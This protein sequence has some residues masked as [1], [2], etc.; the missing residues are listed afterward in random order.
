[1]PKP[2]RLSGLCLQVVESSHFI[3][4]KTADF[5]GL[6]F[7][8]RTDGDS[9]AALARSASATTPYNCS[10][11]PK[12]R[13]G[14]SP[15]GTGGSEQILRSGLLPPQLARSGHASNPAVQCLPGLRRACPYWTR[16]NH[17]PGECRPGSDCLTWK[18][19]Q[20][21]VVNTERSS[22]SDA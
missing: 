8:P 11:R 19:F 3:C 15:L 18:P 10:H 13:T 14:L 22:S 7:L 2:P 9:F 12:E 6:W 16:K 17:L 5:G 21:V 1:M 4:F 20:F